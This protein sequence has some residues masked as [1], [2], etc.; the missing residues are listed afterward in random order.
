MAQQFVHREGE[1]PVSRGWVLVK[2]EGRSLPP[3]V[4][5]LGVPTHD[6]KLIALSRIA[7]EQGHGAWKRALEAVQHPLGE[8]DA[9]RLFSRR[10]ELPASLRGFCL[11]F[12][13]RAWQNRG[14]Q[15]FVRTLEYYG[16]DW[17][18]GFRWL[19]FGWS[20]YVRLVEA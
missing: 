4:L 8:H 10:R 2:D 1:T 20:S 13:G 9:Q 14:G 15:L 6:L 7:G 3:G 5:S 16:D 11:V 12:A 19:G 17:H 18:L